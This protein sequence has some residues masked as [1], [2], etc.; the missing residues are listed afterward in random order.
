MSEQE[1][2]YETE[3]PFEEHLP[4]AQFEQTG[5][6]DEFVKQTKMEFPHFQEIEGKKRVTIFALE[7]TSDMR[8]TIEVQLGDLGTH[9]S[10]HDALKMLDW[11][12]SHRETITALSQ[13]LDAAALSADMRDI[14][15]IKRE[16]YDYRHEGDETPPIAR[17]D[18]ESR[19]SK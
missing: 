6:Y 12:Q 9:L 10:A 7:L 8:H 15:R 2:P 14:S 16:W 4:D 1:E 3:E 13:Q 18:T 5:D 11:L 19:A 17:L